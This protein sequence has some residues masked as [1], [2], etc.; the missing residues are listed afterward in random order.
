MALC[1]ASGQIITTKETNAMLAAKQPAAT[2]ERVLPPRNKHDP[3]TIYEVMWRSG[4]DHTRMPPR[5]NAIIEHAGMVRLRLTHGGRETNVITSIT[6]GRRSSHGIELKDLKVSRDHAYIQRREEK[7][8]L[9]DQSSHGTYVKC[10]TGEN[11]KLRHQEMVLQGSGTISF[12]HDGSEKPEELVTF[13]CEVH[14]PVATP[15][16]TPPR[17]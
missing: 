4:G 16:T 10:V 5:L 15:N 12:G 13:M 1:A 7:F 14:E 11:Y 17:V 3:L 9:V 6:I 2:S 8:V